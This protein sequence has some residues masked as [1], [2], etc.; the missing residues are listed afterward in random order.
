MNVLARCISLEETILH[1]RALMEKS[2][3]NLKKNGGRDGPH[4]KTQF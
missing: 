2:F 1:A 3:V 4:S